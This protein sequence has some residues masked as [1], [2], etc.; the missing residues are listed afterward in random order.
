MPSQAIIGF[1]GE[2]TRRGTI[3]GFEAM[4]AMVKAPLDPLP[5]LAAAPA[6]SHQS[7]RPEQKHEAVAAAASSSIRAAETSLH[8]P[9]SDISRWSLA[10]DY[11]SHR[12]GGRPRAL[13]QPVED[14]IVTWILKMK[15]SQS[16]ILERARHEYNNL[17]E[18]QRIGPPLVFSEHWLRDFMLRYNVSAYGSPSVVKTRGK[19]F[20]TVR[21]EYAAFLATVRTAGRLLRCTADDVL[22]LDETRL[23]YERAADKVV[24]VTGALRV[25]VPE[26][27]ST[28][29]CSVVVIT[30]ASGALLKPILI[31]TGTKS[32]PSTAVRCACVS[33]PPICLVT[34][35]PTIGSGG[36][37][38]H[39][40][41][42]H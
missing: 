3:I 27:T 42:C 33:S 13:P 7:H 20:E 14:V 41:A 32:P 4:D 37:K 17:P 34:C 10:G 39:A 23:K 26:R 16:A 21:Q 15:P 30:A 29:A 8:I 12:G 2:P 1:I 38:G 18:H 28:S 35:T 19:T 36:C 24:D 25:D 5:S 6:H 40:A 9:R 31:F 22:N 11:D